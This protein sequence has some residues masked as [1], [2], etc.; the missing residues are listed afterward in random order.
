MI[1]W[2]PWIEVTITGFVYVIVIFF[3]VIRLLNIRTLSFLKGLESYAPYIALVT[4]FSSYV[5]GLVAHM[6]IAKLIACFRPEVR[7]F[8]P[9]KIVQLHEAAPEYLRNSMGL[10][11]GN[12]VLLRHLAIS[13]F[14]LGIA[15]FLWLDPRQYQRQ[16][17]VLP[18]TCLFLSAVFTAT[19]LAHRPDFIQLREI[20]KL[21]A[22]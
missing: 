15:L 14:L 6:A 8:T 12:L 11:Y 19:Y 22:P 5:S 20:M 2:T 3:L 13:V 16:K 10:S 7:F 18:L 1:L 17:V 4:L 9:E 21:Y